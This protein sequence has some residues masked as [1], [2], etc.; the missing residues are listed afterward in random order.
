M[1]V[2]HGMNVEEVKRISGRLT[3]QAS[4]VQDVISKVDALLAQALG[5]WV[6]PDSKKFDALWKSHRPRL[7][8][9]KN[10]LD[11]L[12]RKAMANANTQ[13]TISNQL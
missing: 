8:G 2:T 4:E 1:A 5:A 7:Q 6:G 12:A 3:Q 10:D 9:L 13:S 11:D